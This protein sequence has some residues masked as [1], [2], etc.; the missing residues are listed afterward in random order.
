VSLGA[1]G[2]RIDTESVISILIGGIA[3]G[4]PPGEAAEPAP[5]DTVFPLYASREDAQKRHYT[6]TVTWL[7]RFNQS[8]RGLEVG[9]PVE[10]RG[11]EVG[12]VSEVR[13]EFDRATKEFQIPVLIEIEPERVLAGSVTEME[14][15]EAVDKLVA[16]GCARS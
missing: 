2:V 5:A 6:T 13:I 7:L 15:R 11:I 3:F 4:S 16:L 8:V 10:F 12:Q 9:A 14:R 1:D